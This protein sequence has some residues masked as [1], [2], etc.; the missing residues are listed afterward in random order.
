MRII[1]FKVGTKKKNSWKWN[2]SKWILKAIKEGRALLYKGE[3]NGCPNF[4][5]G[6]LITFLNIQ[7]QSISRATFPDAFQGIESLEFKC[8]IRFTSAISAAHLISL[9]L[10]Q[11][12]GYSIQSEPFWFIHGRLLNILLH[13]GKGSSVWFSS[14]RRVIS[15]NIYA[16]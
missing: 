4:C 12:N 10:L 6:H 13:L 7:S 5:K 1:K 3:K 15:L 16:V 2:G 14:F 9:I 11:I 8:V